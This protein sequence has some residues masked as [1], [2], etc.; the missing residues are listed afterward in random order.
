[1]KRE[2]STKKL[3]EKL[4]AIDSNKNIYISETDKIKKKTFK[5]FLKDNTKK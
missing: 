5:D 1:M 3:L 2:N 4:K